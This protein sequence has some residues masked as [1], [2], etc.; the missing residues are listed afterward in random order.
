MVQVHQH[1]ADGDHPVANVV[2][3][4]RHVCGERV[5]QFILADDDQRLVAFSPRVEEG[6]RSGGDVD[7]AA[8][9][10]LDRLPVARQAQAQPLGTGRRQ[11]DQRAQLLAFAEGQGE[12]LE[13]TAQPRRFDPGAAALA[14]FV[15]E[16]AQMHFL[17]FTGDGVGCMLAHQCD[18]FRL[19][20]AQAVAARRRRILA[21]KEDHGDFL[22]VGEDAGVVELAQHLLHHCRIAAGRQHQLVGGDALVLAHLQERGEQPEVEIR[23]GDAVAQQLLLRSFDPGDL[24]RAGKHA[25]LV[26]HPPQQLRFLQ[27]GDRHADLGVGVARS[28]VEAGV[29]GQFEQDFAGR[30]DHLAVA[31]RLALDLAQGLEDRADVALRQARVAQQAE[32]E[33]EVGLVPEQDAARQ[34]LIASGATGFLQV[35]FER[36]GRV[37]VDHQAHVG[38]VDAHAEGVGRGDHAQLAADERLLHAA[39]LVG[40]EPAVEMRCVDAGLAQEGGELLGRLLP[41]AEDDHAAGFAERILDQLQCPR[42]LL[43]RGNRNHLVGEVVARYAAGED[44]ELDAESLAEMRD[45]V[46]D[47]VRL[48]RRS[49]GEH[50]RHLLVAAT[51]EA[52]DVEVV[53]PEV[54]SPLREAVRLVEHPGG[55]FAMPQRVGKR[56]AAELF[57]GDEDD[58]E[59]AQAQA[60]EHLLAFE[61]CQES[62]EE[63][64]AVHAALQ[65]IVDLVLHQRLQGRDDD[66]ERAGAV[67]AR[68]RRQLVAQ[69]LAAAGRQDRQR[70]PARVAVAHDRLLQGTPVAGRRLLPEVVD[71]RKV[72]RQ[73]PAELVVLPAP[74]AIGVGAGRVAQLLQQL[75]GRREMDAHPGRQ[76]R[77]AAGDAQPDEDVGERPGSSRIGEVARKDAR[78][79]AAAGLAFGAT[80]EG[81]ARRCDRRAG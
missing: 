41:C 42:E 63:A 28:A 67:E 69:G 19:D 26:F 60:V 18:Q 33:V 24:Q 75:G 50:G 64:G 70:R 53:G 45:D 13:Q 29:V 12:R 79:R 58:A 74:G 1:G 73:L 44:F 80:D 81:R 22:V 17:P 47:D 78:E 36:T 71:S 2:A 77:V 59:V 6:K 27:P 30:G 11:V 76:H 25:R 32:L 55:D 35:V 68:Q 39:L 54:V 51:D 15:T 10:R 20:P 61:R 38:L 52:R 7:P 49:E 34:R 62:V 72:Q 37:E 21:G 65:Q 4:E 46:F 31:A 43:L 23:F 48:R 9:N 56:R 40:V 14:Q 57:G 66:G 16:A 8:G 5:A 3:G